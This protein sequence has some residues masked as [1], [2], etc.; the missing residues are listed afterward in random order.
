VSITAVGFVPAAPLLVPQVAGGS[1]QLDDELRDACRE[2]ARRLVAVTDDAITVVA[3]VASEATWSPD[4]TWGFEGFGVPRRPADDR[5]RLPW[6]LGI[7]DWLLDDVAWTGTRHHLGV[8]GDGT[9]SPAS[10]AGS[11]GGLLV[12]GDG[13]A[14]RTEKAPGHLDER[15]EGLDATIAAAIRSGDVAGLGSLDASLATELLCAGAPVW[16]WLMTVV[17]GRSVVEAELLSDTAPY[18]VGYFAGW[19]QLSG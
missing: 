18:G 13:T 17:A 4:A 10:S 14:R 8:F 19:W 6:P 12:V 9:A 11:A 1:A 16:R 5:P 3:P 7:G 2:V 15:A